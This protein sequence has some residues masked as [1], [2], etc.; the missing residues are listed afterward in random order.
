MPRILLA[1]ARTVL[2]GDPQA[3][4][5]RGVCCGLGFHPVMWW[6]VFSGSGSE[7]SCGFGFK[8]LSGPFKAWSM[9]MQET[10]CGFP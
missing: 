6:L 4:S 10:V 5:R 2:R 1:P 8:L 3:S 9:A 7:Y